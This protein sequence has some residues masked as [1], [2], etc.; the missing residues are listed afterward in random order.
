MS[1]KIRLQDDLKAALRENDGVRKAA[2]RLTLAAIKNAE[3]AKIG[4]LSDDEALALLRTE[5]KR[6][7]ETIAELEKVGRPELLAEEQAQLAVIDGYLPQPMSREQVAEVVQA[8]LARMGHPPAK[9][10]GAAMKQV[11]AELKGKAD[12]KLVQEVLRELMQ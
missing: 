9:E 12:G 2:L 11:M 6:R 3:V 7:R 8:V 5:V 1:L 10:F 4:E